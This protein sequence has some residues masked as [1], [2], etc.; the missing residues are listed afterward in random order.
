MA[1]RPLADVSTV[2]RVWAVRT[3]VR[4]GAIRLAT[5][6]RLDRLA[7]IRARLTGA[8]HGVSLVRVVNGHHTL[9]A[10]SAKLFRQLSWARE[11]FAFVRPLEFLEL[12]SGR[13]RAADARPA[14][15]LTFDDGLACHYQVAAPLLE[16]LD[17]RAIFFVV[18]EF[19]M[20][21]T[22]REAREYFVERIDRAADANRLRPE[23]YLP[24]TPEQMRALSERGHSIGN[25]T[26][27]HADLRGVEDM[28]E[29]AREVVAPRAVLAGWTGTS[30]YAFAWTFGWDRISRTAWRL[31]REHHDL[32]FGLC[33]G[34]FRVGM[35]SPGLIRRT[36]VEAHYASAEYQF[37]YSGLADWF[38]ESRAR[39]LGK[40]L[41]GPMKR[42][43]S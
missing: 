14:V 8:I 17:L 24:M 3:A 21:R 26:M 32:C 6:A 27:T 34:V 40:R 16:S 19:S 29:L 9:E 7:R 15:L 12:A 1:T 10:D 38:W 13:R 5:A 42:G 28:A 20:C 30:P 36:T 43:I 33:P 2:S 35:D 37:M 25:H 23:Q 41:H 11:H 4:S 18:P 31:A 22:P 39:A